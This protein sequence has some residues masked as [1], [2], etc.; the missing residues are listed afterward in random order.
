[1]YGGQFIDSHWISGIGPGCLL[2]WDQMSTLEHICSSSHYPLTLGFLRRCSAPLPLL[3]NVGKLECEFPEFRFRHAYEL[4]VYQ[5]VYQ[6]DGPL[7]SIPCRFSSLTHFDCL[8][9]SPRPN[10]GLRYDIIKR[11]ML[12]HR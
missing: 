3:Q 6:A 10:Q 1:M 5:Q 7:H 8:R 12:P 11:G 2:N 9:L 4:D